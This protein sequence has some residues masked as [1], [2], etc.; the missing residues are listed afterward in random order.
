[1][2]STGLRLVS[3]VWRPVT[4]TCQTGS[5]MPDGLELQGLGQALKIGLLGA[6]RAWHGHQE[7][8]L[9]HPRQPAVQA[10]LALD[11]PRALAGDLLTEGLWG[12]RAPTGAPG[13]VQGYV[14]R[15]R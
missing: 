14:S 3:F 7:V 2:I 15:L 9:G 13:M 5:D 10:V 1:M 11:A 4:T 6:V 12:D 8:L